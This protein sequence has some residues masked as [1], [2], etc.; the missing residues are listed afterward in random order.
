MCFIDSSSY[1]TIITTNLNLTDYR[2][3]LVKAESQ[4]TQTISTFMRLHY[5]IIVDY[6]NTRK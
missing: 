1:L 6:C 5:A 2:V 3:K 4:F